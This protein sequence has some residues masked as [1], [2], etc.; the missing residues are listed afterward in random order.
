S[1]ASPCLTFVARFGTSRLKV[2]SAGWVSVPRPPGTPGPPVVPGWHP[3][4]TRRVA[5]RRP[6]NSLFM[7]LVPCLEKKRAPH[8]LP[9]ANVR[10]G[11]SEIGAGSAI[12]LA[13]AAEI[14]DLAFGSVL[15]IA[16]ALLE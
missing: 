13:S 7:S 5:L 16:V 8:R 11:P 2:F 10:Q 4:P 9:H 15:L 6:A 3:T 1:L 14:I 12:S